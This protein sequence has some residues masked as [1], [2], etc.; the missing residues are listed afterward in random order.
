VRVAILQLP[1]KFK[2][3]SGELR[4]MLHVVVNL[5]QEII[6]KLVRQF[7]TTGGTAARQLGCI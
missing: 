7:D 4:L 2:L 6:R 5:T 3:L 1:E